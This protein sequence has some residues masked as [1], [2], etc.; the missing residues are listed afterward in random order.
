M[1]YE[2]HQRPTE[3]QNFE[4]SSDYIYFDMRKTALIFYL[5]CQV[6]QQL[7][8]E[9]SVIIAGD[10]KIKRHFVSWLAGE[11]RAVSRKRNRLALSESFLLKAGGCSRSTLERFSILHRCGSFLKPWAVQRQDLNRL[12][13]EYIDLEA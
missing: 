1:G 5:Q 3:G 4:M 12:R 7:E 13:F 10:S 8:E 2:D 11:C 9:M 6:G